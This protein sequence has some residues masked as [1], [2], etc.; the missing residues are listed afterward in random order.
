MQIRHH[1]AGNVLLQGFGQPRRADK[2]DVSAMLAK[3]GCPEPDPDLVAL[4]M[5][6]EPLLGGCRRPGNLL[7]RFPLRKGV[8]RGSAV[9]EKLRKVRSRIGLLFRIGWP[10]KVLLGTTAVRPV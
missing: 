2:R 5:D 9:S 3:I 10:K 6:A 1:V 8:D 7:N 4:E